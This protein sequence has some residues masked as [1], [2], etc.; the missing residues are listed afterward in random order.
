MLKDIVAV[1]ALDG[2]CL[3]LRFE[4]GVDGV[5]DLARLVSFIGV[6]APLL[7]RKEFAAVRI[8]SELGTICWPSGG[9]LDPDV[10]YA[11]VTGADLPRYQEATAPNQ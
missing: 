6:F 5:V 3:K 11:V 9:D 7:D 1:E 4:D 2:Y 8:N 10:L